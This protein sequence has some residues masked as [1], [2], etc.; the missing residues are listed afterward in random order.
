MTGPVS[1]HTWIVAAAY[2]AAGVIGALALRVLFTRLHRRAENARWRGGDIMVA[3]RQRHAALVEATLSAARDEL[4]L[5]DVAL[6]THDVA[7][8]LLDTL[9]GISHEETAEG[10]LDA[11]GMKFSVRQEAGLSSS[12]RA[13]SL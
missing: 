3:F 7:A 11:H 1:S 5:L 13:M 9:V 2:L 12:W 10:A 4:D 8:L 6:P